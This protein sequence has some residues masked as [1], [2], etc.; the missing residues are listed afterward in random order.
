MEVAGLVV[1]VIPLAIT[2]LHCYEE[3][4]S[5]A[6]KIR[7]KNALVRSLGRAL[8]GYDAILTVNIDWLLRS[9]GCHE[10][11]EASDWTT[12]LQ[13]PE[14]IA[15]TREMLG[16]A[17][18]KAFHE[19]ILE[20]CDALEII[21]RKIDGFLAVA[22]KDNGYHDKMK[23]LK[24]IKFGSSD[25]VK[26][27]YRQ[28]FKLALSSRQIEECISKVEKATNILNSIR[29]AKSDMQWTES[30]DAKKGPLKKIV[31]SLTRV[32]GYA[33]QLHQA[34]SSCWGHEQ[35]PS[36]HQV[37]LHLQDRLGSNAGEDSVLFSVLFM[38]TLNTHKS[39][40]W[41]Q[42]FI[43]VLKPDVENTIDDLEEKFSRVKFQVTSSKSLS[44]PESGNVLS[45]ICLEV[46][47]GQKHQGIL[48][49]CIQPSPKNQ[50]QIRKMDCLEASPTAYVEETIALEDLLHLS[51]SP[52]SRLRLYPRACTELA[53]VL[54]S[55]VLQLSQTSWFVEF[56]TKEKI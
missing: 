51:N 10:D 2:A 11:N 26:V 3:T 20:S 22:P 55:G 24:G 35:C 54:A 32:R 27:R 18:A 25:D 46:C 41:R 44:S 33:S 39:F 56:W 7:R 48:Q 47:N 50:C 52:H 9:I 4:Q 30:R 13:K 31:R 15:R 19:A 40:Q 23:I 16:D 49:L 42:S 6:S 34:I 8:G 14:T 12:L 1:G 28:G 29:S 45:S 21:L 43:K 36:D 38:S 37:R 5:F 53:L 17:V